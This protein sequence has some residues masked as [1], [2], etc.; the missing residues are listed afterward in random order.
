MPRIVPGERVPEPDTTAGAESWQYALPM[1]EGLGVFWM[2]AG[3]ML[4][5]TIHDDR[6][7]PGQ[8]LQLVP[9]FGH[10]LGLLLG[11]AFQRRDR[12]LAMGL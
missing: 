6:D 10:V 11:E 3:A 8:P 7:I 4:E 9:G 1:I 5:R 2:Q 12:D